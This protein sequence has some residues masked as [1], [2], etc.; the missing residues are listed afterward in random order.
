MR[1][2]RHELLQDRTNDATVVEDNELAYTHA[3]LTYTYSGVKNGLGIGDYFRLTITT[4]NGYPEIHTKVQVN[5][6]LAYYFR[7]FEGTTVVT[8]GTVVNLINKNRNSANT[9]N[10]LVRLDDVTS[11]D[12]SNIIFQMHQAQGILTGGLYAQPSKF[13]LKQNES[14]VFELE[15]DANSNL[16]SGVVEFQEVWTHWGGNV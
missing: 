11:G 13:I 10:S 15:S 3:G 7:I 1:H 12:T 9:A 8:S 16:L 14:Y 5:G 4:P 6:K 2:I